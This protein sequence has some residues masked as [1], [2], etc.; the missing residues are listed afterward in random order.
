MLNI[1]GNSSVLELRKL[2]SGDICA[3]AM[4]F[5]RSLG[6]LMD[7]HGVSCLHALLGLDFE[8]EGIKVASFERGVPSESRHELFDR[9][10]GCADG[11]AEWLDKKEE[12]RV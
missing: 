12:W 7:E 8:L 5:D 3:D 9:L 2:E 6:N 4:I 10:L 1:N 11:C